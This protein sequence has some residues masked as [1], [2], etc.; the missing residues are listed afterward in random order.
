MQ[1]RD[2]M[3]TI[4]E[5]EQCADPLSAYAR[6]IHQTRYRGL[7]MTHFQNVTTVVAINLTRLL[8]WL[9]GYPR[10][11]SRQSRFAALAA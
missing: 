7:A 5:D 6:D 1:M 9:S 10:A 3:G 11:Q 4:Y 2:E 8:A